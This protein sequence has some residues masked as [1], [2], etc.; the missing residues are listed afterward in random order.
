SCISDGAKRYGALATGVAPDTRLIQNSTILVGRSPNE[1]FGK[2]SF[3]IQ[4]YLQLEHY[5]LWEVIEFGDSYKVPANTDPADSR[6]GRTITATTEDI[7]KKKNDVKA[8]T[9][10]LLSLP[11]EHQLRFSKYKTARELWAAILKTFGG[12]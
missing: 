6:T 7:Q 5:A 1:S 8:R 9:T 10:L 12:N 3:R 2:A 4:Q 11:D